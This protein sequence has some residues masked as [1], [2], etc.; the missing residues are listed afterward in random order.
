[1]NKGIYVYTL[2]INNKYINGN[3][4]VIIFREG[5]FTKFIQY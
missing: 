4:I 2:S 5:K 1:M 3:V